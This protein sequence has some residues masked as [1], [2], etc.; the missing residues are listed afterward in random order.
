MAAIASKH[1]LLEIRNNGNRR[2]RH[3]RVS[4]ESWG[5]SGN[6]DSMG[7]NCGYRFCAWCG[8]RHAEKK[9]WRDQHEPNQKSA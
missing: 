2:D 1:G 3:R 9:Q 5:G 7:R 8:E 4:E 6:G